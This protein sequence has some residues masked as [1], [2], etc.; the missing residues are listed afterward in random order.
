VRLFSRRG[1]Q[2]DRKRILEQAVTAQQK[3]RH[4]KAANLYRR[5]IAVEPNN[6]DLQMRI[7][8]CLAEAGQPF[9]AWE[10]YRLA[11]DAL[12]KAARRE[13]AH[14]LLRDAARRLPRCYEA[15][16]G[17]A[18]LELAM[19]NKRAALD[20]LNRAQKNFRRR[21][22]RS[23]AIALLKK[24]REIEPD[25]LSTTME[26]ARLLSKSGRED[27]ALDLLGHVV[28]VASHTELKQIRKQQWFITPTV[29]HTWL[30]LRASLSGTS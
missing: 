9:D 19:E 10:S 11:A 14:Q 21:S 1:T 16:L 20:V 6:V 17:L 3:G 4:R 13:H 22:Q 12:L 18:S 24:M 23:Q 30:W 28:E 7:A 29:S 2:Y 15:W 25:E 26:L 27:E 5:I 8:P